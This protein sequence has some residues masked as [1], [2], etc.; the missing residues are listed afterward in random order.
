M[1]TLKRPQQSYIHDHV[2]MDKE[3]HYKTP[4]WLGR[5]S[6]MIHKD[7]DEVFK[8]DAECKLIYA[9]LSGFGY[10]HGWNNIYPNREKIS[11]DL[12]I[13]LRN[14]S[15]KMKV[16][17]GSGL[18]DIIPTYSNRF[19]SQYSSNRYRVKRSEQVPRI[20]WYNRKGVELV[21]DEYIFKQQNFQSYKTA[22]K[23]YEVV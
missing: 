17:S 19:V 15:T 11:D 13:T 23:Y 8:I 14:V 5:I 3:F 4:N 20:K 18:I 2:D 6:K 21:T 7:T 16:L 22:S 10:A 9:Y 1:T 12:G